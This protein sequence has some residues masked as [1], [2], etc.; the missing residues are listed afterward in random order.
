M[1]LII[2]LCFLSLLLMAQVKNQVLLKKIAQRIKLLREKKAITQ[3]EFYYDTGIHLGRIETGTM[4]ITVSTLDA[5]C[6][7]FGISL[8]EFFKEM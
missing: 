3:E 4:N 7:Y 8:E 2:F 1:S 5:I 6:M